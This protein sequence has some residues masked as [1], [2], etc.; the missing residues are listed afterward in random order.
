MHELRQAREWALPDGRRVWV[1][2][3][4]DETLID[5]AGPARFRLPSAHKLVVRIADQRWELA[6]GE[7][8]HIA[9][10]TLVYEGLRTWMGYR[11][12]RDPTLPWLLASALVS[13]LALALHY[14]LKFV[15]SQPRPR[16]ALELADG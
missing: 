14:A 12:T 4:F 1:M 8:A 10:G 2:L 13:A 9:G 15:R 11:V 5:P 3:Q 16:T 7:P 6:V